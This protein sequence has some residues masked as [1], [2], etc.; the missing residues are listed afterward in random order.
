MVRPLI[1]L[2]SLL[3][4]PCLFGFSQ[5]ANNQLITPESKNKILENPKDRFAGTSDSALLEIPTGSISIV[6]GQR[7]GKYHNI[8]L[9]NSLAGLLPGL[10]VICHGGEPGNDDAQLFIR[11]LNTIG[12]NSPLVIVDGIPFRNIGRL[13]PDDI[14]TISV[15]KD[16]SAAIY[17]MQGAN[18]V[19]L[20]TTMRGQSGKPIISID[21]NSGLAQPAKIPDMA[22][23]ITYATMLNEISYY[24]NPSGGRF[25]I[26]S[27]NDLQKYG[28]GSDPWHYP[29][30]DWFKEVIKPL[31]YQT[32]NH[33]SASGTTGKIGYFFSLGAIYEDGNYKKSST[34]Y[35]QYDFRT[36]IDANLSRNIQLTFDISGQNEN[37][38]Y[39]SIDAGTIYSYLLRGEPVMPAYW[40]NGLPGPDIEYGDNPAVISTDAPGYN[41]FISNNLQS[42]AGLK[43]KIPW[44]KGLSA[45]VDA[46]SDLINIDHSKLTRPWY[47]YT[48]DG[49][50]LDGDGN[51]L[52][53]KMER[54]VVTSINEKDTQRAH[55]NIYNAFLSYDFSIASKHMF[56][57]VTGYEMQQGKEWYLDDNIFYAINHGRMGCYGKIGYSFSDRYLAEFAWKYDGSDV[58]SPGHQFGF[59]PALSVGWRISNEPFWKK[60]IRLLDELD[61]R[62]S[63]GRTGSDRNINS[64]LINHDIPNPD[65]TCEMA[66]QFNS[67]F[68]AS[69]LN[70]HFTL[71]VDYFYHLR[72]RIPLIPGNSIPTGGISLPLENIG[73]V[74]NQGFEFTLGYQLNTG[75]LSYEF[76]LTGSYSKNKIIST[77][78]APGLPVYQQSTGYSTE[79]GLYYESIGI[80]RDAASL[81]AYP[82]WTGAVPGDII[83]KDINNDKVI[84]GLDR[85]RMD[86]TDVPKF[87]GGFCANVKFRHLDLS[88]F[89]Q[90]AR[91]AFVYVNPE[92]GITGNFYQEYAE[93]R[94]TPEHPGN[95]G[96]RSWNRDDEY[97]RN[98][99]N[100]FWLQPT[101]YIR[102]KNLEIGYTFNPGNRKKSVDRE[103]RIYLN[104]FNL[105]TFSRFKFFDPEMLTGAA[106]PPQRILNIGLKLSI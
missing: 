11:G 18:G 68:N 16:A 19:I 95:T 84:D 56:G 29:N 77:D 58:F 54:G 6:S 2:L 96:P 81:D 55:R 74:K 25:Q 72:S 48:W 105:L 80:F 28:N 52:L 51:P 99:L 98:Q 83:F 24:N 35:S 61:I 10:T 44:I 106:Y 60:S 9:T 22:D 43:I 57:I 13:S 38:H 49:V 92:S 66:T 17:G 79:S 8:N 26:Y 15:V 14:G 46:S 40:P 67:G 5:P 75:E 91:G 73:K 47:L 33:I 64:F 82:H 27:D 21:H 65:L 70:K 102:I 62:A 1:I 34:N 7:L 20:V 89:F 97:W 31:S 90:G 94:W 36:N 12:N 41:R 76:S 88:L 104:G 37:S 86:E 23:A 69:F 103:L 50:S 53:F 39:S 71:N 30:T 59:F 4:F 101:D 87:T 3:L 32:T 42:K 63:I 100:T 45:N 78:E 93:N 85:I